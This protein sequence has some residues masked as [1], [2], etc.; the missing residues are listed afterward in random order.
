MSPFRCK[1][2]RRFMMSLLGFNIQLR[3]PH[4]GVIPLWTPRLHRRPHVWSAAT[5]KMVFGASKTTQDSYVTRYTG[6]TPLDVRSDSL[7]R[8][9]ETLTSAGLISKVIGAQRQ[10]IRTLVQSV[11]KSLKVG[12]NC[13]SMPSKHNTHHLP[14]CVAKDS[15][16]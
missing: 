12:H 14:V 8:P 2:E 4:M 9:N 6:A 1:S 7:L 5:S 3:Q 10:A 13:S 16:G 11:E 15:H